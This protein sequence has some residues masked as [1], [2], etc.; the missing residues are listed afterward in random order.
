MPHFV[1][2]GGANKQVTAAYFG[3]GGAWK[4]VIARWI[5]VG[6]VWKKYFD[7]VSAVVL[8]NH[9]VFTAGTTPASSGY[10]IGSDGVAYRLN[11]G[12][13]T[14]YSGEWLNSGV[15]SDYQV[16][17]EHIGGTSVTGDGLDVWLPCSTTRTWT[18]TANSVPVS[19]QLLIR[20]R[21]ASDL[22]EVATAEIDLSAETTL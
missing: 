3:V 14:A 6:G 7:S 1:A 17:A 5:G 18:V 8:A 13:P 2:S 11:N 4:A 16:R 21:R 10:R 20:I 12:V 19:A 9:F 22:A 15:A